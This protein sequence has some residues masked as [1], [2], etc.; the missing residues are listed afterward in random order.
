M[1]MSFDEVHVTHSCVRDIW[2]FE[3]KTALTDPASIFLAAQKSMRTE[4]LWEPTLTPWQP[5]LREIVA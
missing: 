2:S 3:I 4:A 1:N 5:P